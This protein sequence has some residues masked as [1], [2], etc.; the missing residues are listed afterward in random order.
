M[1]PRQG[2]LPGIC[3]LSKRFPLDRSETVHSG[4]VAVIPLSQTV[5]FRTHLPEK[6]PQGL[7]GAGIVGAPLG[8]LGYVR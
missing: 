8:T 1:N 5:L 3:L 6:P 7:C 2:N 4:S